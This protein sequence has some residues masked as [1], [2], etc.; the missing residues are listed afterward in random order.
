M[1]AT[2]KPMTLAD[3]NEA[4]AS[5]AYRLSEVCAIYPITPSSTMGELADEWSAVNRQN[6]WGEVPLIAEMQSE[7]GAAGAIHGALQ[8]GALCSTFTASQGLLLMIPNMYKI[9]GE[10]TPTVF[11]VA[12]RAIAGHGLSIFGDHQDV[13]AARQ[14]GFAMLGGAS[15]QEAHDMALIAHS[16]TLRAR[17]PFIHFFDGFRTSH[18]IS[19]V[20][21]VSDDVIRQMVREED[22]QA[23]RARGLN[24]ERPVLRGTAMNPDVYFQA[25]EAANPYYAA[26]PGIVEEMMG[27]FAELT[28]RTYKL[29]DYYGHPEAERVMVLMGSGADAARETADYLVGQGERVGVLQVRLYRPFS[30]EHLLAALP[31]SV[32]Q[33]A[34]LDRTK[35]PGAPGEPLYLDVVTTLAQA[36]AAGT[37]P[38]E[39]MPVITGGRY[40]LSSKEFNPA[41]IRAVFDSLKESRPRHPFTVG[42][43][44]DVA[45]TSLEWDENFQLPRNGVRALFYGL[46]SDGTVGANK[47]TIKIIGEETDYYTQGYFVYDSKKS[48]S[49]TVSHLR[50]GDAPI[51]SSYLITE[52]DFI[53]CHQSQFLD[54][55]DVLEHAAEGATFLLNSIHPADALWDKL[56]LT[57]QRTILKKKVKVYTIDAYHVARNAGMGARINTIMQTCF[58]AI[59][60]V[61]PREEAIGKIK[62]A[63]RK[64]YGKKGEDVVE[65]NF[66]AVDAALAALHEVPIRSGE[67]ATHDFGIAVSEDAP[68]FVREVTALMMAD[69]GDKLPVSALPVDGTYPTATTRWE[70]R[71]IATRVPEWDPDVCIQCGNC[72]FVCPH[73]CIRAKLYDEKELEKAPEGFRAS[74]LRGRGFPEQRYTLQIYVED[75]TGCEM[76]VSV[77]PAKNKEKAGLKAIN[78]VEKDSLHEREVRNERFF[79]T[80]PETSREN[81]N[82]ANVRGVQYLQPLFEFSG[83]C[84]GCGETPYLKLLSQLF[85]DRMLI[86]NATGC[87]SIYGGNLPT[88]PWSVN[89]EGCG[90]A[91]SNSLFEDN[92]E[93]GFGYSLTNEMHSRM[94]RALLQKLAPR[95]G[96]EMVREILEETQDTDDSISA[97]RKRVRAL[98]QQLRELK[99]PDAAQL[100]TL[101]D[102]LI[103]RSVWIIGGDG[104]AYDIGFGGLDHVLATGRN[105]NILVLDTEVYSNTGGQSSKSTPLGAIAKFATAGK[106]IGKKDLGMM[107]MSYGHVYV[108]KVAMGANRQQVIQ[109]MR[110]AEAYPGPSL[111]LA[112]SHCIAHGISM[113]DGLDQQKLATQCGHWPLFR[114]DPRRAGNSENPLQLDSP[115]PRKS[116]K[117]YA[118][119]EIRYRMLARFN[120]ER[121][122]LL[123]EKA[124]SHVERQWQRYETMAQVNDTEED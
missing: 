58:F 104:W 31:A 37:L 101:A 116:F 111:I 4:A 86:A 44:D 8:T 6:I 85:G 3:G 91:W 43:H 75:C 122:G 32:R 16:A 40:G 54:Q 60:G 47:N 64:T 96:D 50:F 27:C 59:S 33:I 106:D 113:K 79:E 42:I 15:V 2:K 99:E 90:P 73:S 100:L 67:S 92:A 14:T 74:K 53:G 80:L 29:M 21:F 24:P 87:S 28:G 123:M 109:A 77:C 76:C 19:K 10:L 45:H 69:K 17:V 65:K 68:A 23:H 55:I 66:A 82:Y 48:G 117:E 78:M 95:I 63:I 107:A 72:A 11:H 46:G 120:P 84:A 93:F 20:S 22:I 83:A 9:A 89:E 38:C 35:E 108:A 18:E 61:L 39:Q 97:Q 49:R 41:M 62:E 103:R 94:A 119:N 121:A 105:V 57:T 71:N 102:Q 51:R 98:K 30:A 36:Y 124:Q 26:L 70:K 112:Y 1:I 118:Y 12:A 81:I 114:F 34:V 110:E 13:M 88:T 25:R 115:A 52:A 56:P 5:I 7:G